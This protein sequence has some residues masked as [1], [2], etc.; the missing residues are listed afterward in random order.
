MADGAR[1]L[2][3]GWGRC[4]GRA[5]RTAAAAATIYF[6]WEAGAVAE[7]Y[8]HAAH[9][10]KEVRGSEL[11]AHVFT[12]SAARANDNRPAVVFFHGGGWHMGEPEW[13]FPECRY[14][15]ARGMVAVAI[16]YRLV[17]RGASSPV[18]CMADAK[19]AIRW[20]RTRA[21]ELGIDP[22]RIVAAGSSSGGHLA[23]AAATIDDFDDP[24]EDL[25]ISSAPDA[26]MLWFPAVDVGRDPWFVR[27]LSGVAEVADCSPVSHVREGLPPTIVFQGDADDLTPLRGAQRFSDELTEAGNRCDLY[28]YPGRGHVF[29]EDGRDLADT[30][31]RADRFLV[32]LGYLDGEPDAAALEESGATRTAGPRR[33]GRRG[34]PPRSLDVP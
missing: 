2:R 1:G 23:A 27:L 22:E 24:Q 16:E 6:A 29:T 19:S 20:V 5:A 30:L 34:P 25:E 11:A 21:G 17:E 3:G 12:P 15:A 8:R 31:E 13:C 9:V 26:L 18:D 4:A 33:P 14:F 7:P 10:Y 32:T 28:V